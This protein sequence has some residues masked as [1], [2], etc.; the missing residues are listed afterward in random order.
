MAEIDLNGWH[1][2]LHQI[3]GTMA[4]RWCR[5]SAD[6]LR[7]WSV[8]LRGIAD[9]M[10]ARANATAAAPTR[11]GTRGSYKATGYGCSL[12]KA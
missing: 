4:L 12:C 11:A 6:D 8:T 1:R 10:Q 3:T 7:T 5:A 9:A 2:Q